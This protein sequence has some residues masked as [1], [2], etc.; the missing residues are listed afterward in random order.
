MIGKDAE[1]AEDAEAQRVTGVQSIDCRA[2]DEIGRKARLELVFSVRGGRTVLTHG[3]AEPPFRIGA[4]L[5][6]CH[7]AR[8][9]LAWSAPGVFGGDCLEQRMRVERGAS[10]TIASQSALQAHPS[11]GGAIARMRTIVEVEEE[12]ELRCDWDPLIPFSGAR[13]SQRYEVRLAPA[14]TL[15]WS[16]AFMSGREGRGERWAFETLEHELAVSCGGTL[17]YLE[18]YRLEPGTQPL[19][20]PWVAA[21]CCYFGTI[22]ARFRSNASDAS[23]SEAGLRSNVTD[24]SCGEAGRSAVQ[25]PDSLQQE[26]SSFDGL[27]GAVDTLDPCLK[28]VRLMASRGTPFHDARA[29]VRRRLCA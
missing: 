5:P 24:A 11:P 1:G 3:Y 27:R 26:L 17:A 15:Y 13:L 19:T 4:M 23:S 2:G 6:D 25:A 8:M 7:G 18:R 9:I 16:D 10:V 14:A 20:A 12:A 22:L 21:D 29:L 28:L